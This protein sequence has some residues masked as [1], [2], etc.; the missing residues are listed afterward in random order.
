[1]YEQRGTHVPRKQHDDYTDIG[2]WGT[3]KTISLHFTFNRD[4]GI[5]HVA[6]LNNM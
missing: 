6:R 1:M 5:L 3:T 2:S 4:V